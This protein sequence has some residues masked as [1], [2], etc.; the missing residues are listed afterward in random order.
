MAECKNDYER[1]RRVEMRS[2]TDVGTCF[3][4]AVPGTAL[5]GLGLCRSFPEGG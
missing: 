2:G 1:W 3:V 4:A 5:G